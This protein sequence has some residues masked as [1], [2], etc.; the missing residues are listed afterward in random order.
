MNYKNAPKTSWWRLWSAW[1]RRVPRKLRHRE[2]KF[3]YLEIMQELTQAPKTPKILNFNRYVKASM[4]YHAHGGKID[5]ET[6]TKRLLEEV[7][8]A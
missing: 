2:K 6:I 8:T 3:F 7:K 1:A 4:G 5:Q